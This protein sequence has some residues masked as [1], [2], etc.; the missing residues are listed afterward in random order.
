MIIEINTTAELLEF[1]KRDEVTAEQ[2]VQVVCKV[3]NVIS[4]FEKSKDEL[5]NL[6]ED[7]I[8]KYYTGEKKETPLFL[9]RLN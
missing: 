5:I 2:G 9:E 3:L 8:N 7:Y 6:T 1:I 4:L